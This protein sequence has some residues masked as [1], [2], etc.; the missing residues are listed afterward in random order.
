[1]QYTIQD[2]KPL[3]LGAQRRNHG[4]NFALFSRHAT[5]VE[6]LLYETSDATKH[7]MVI[8]LDPA[9]HR[10]GDI[11]HIYLQGIGSGVAYAWHV[12]G[13]YQPQQGLRYNRYKLLLDPCAKALIDTDRWNFAAARGF[14]PDSTEGDLSFD[15]RDN[16]TCAARCLVVEDVCR[17]LKPDLEA[18][19]RLAA[20][21][22][23]RAFAE[24]ALGPCP[25]ASD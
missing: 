8:Q 19:W 17:R 16:E 20:L 9:V 24:R 23:G 12:D 21:C 14:I 6:L 1:M 15:D 18:R 3:P 2:G 7:S 4:V 5:A 10:T 22:Y 25:G 11:W 13:P